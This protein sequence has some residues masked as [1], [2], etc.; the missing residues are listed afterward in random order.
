MKVLG[1]QSRLTLFVTPW[2]V[3]LQDPLSL[4]FSKQGHWSG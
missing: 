2:T 4:E 3:A 1:A